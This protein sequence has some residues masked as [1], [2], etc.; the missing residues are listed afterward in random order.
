MAKKPDHVEIFAD[1]DALSRAA[2][3]L[4]AERAAAAVAAHGRFSVALSGGRAPQRAYELLAGPPW[5]DRVPWAAVHVF[6]GDERCV[7]ADDP[8]S[9]A[10]AARRALLDRVPAPKHQIH[11][12][13]CAGDPAAGAVQYET[14]LRDFFAGGPPRFDLVLLGLGEDG[15]TASLFPGAAALREQAHWTA[16]VA[17]PTPGPDRVTLTAPALNE[18]AAIVF[19]VSG[20]AKAEVLRR[21]LADGDDVAQAPALLIRPRNG[22]LRWLVDR[23]AASGG[24]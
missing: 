17:A 18:A 10:G 14:L 6:W 12:I 1:Y 3:S 24:G 23:A 16:A 9:N 19:L 5:R 8:R 7:P 13:D 15:H 2:A 11:A 4:F 22:E 20:E 21:V